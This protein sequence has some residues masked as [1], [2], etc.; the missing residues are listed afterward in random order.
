MK[1]LILISLFGKFKCFIEN[2]NKIEEYVIKKTKKYYSTVLLNG[3]KFIELAPDEIPY[4]K[5]NRTIFD[6]PISLGM[7]MIPMVELGI[8]LVN[9]LGKEI[10]N[11]F[12]IVDGGTIFEQDKIIKEI[13]IRQTKRDVYKGAISF[14]ELVNNICFQYSLKSAKRIRILTVKN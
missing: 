10:K 1:T 4:S 2:N 13:F 8:R 7:P 6:I 12:F 11:V 14:A 3:D 9:D 5:G